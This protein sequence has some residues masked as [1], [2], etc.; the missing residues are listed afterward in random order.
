M[1]PGKEHLVFFENLAK[2]QRKWGPRFCVYLKTSELQDARKHISALAN[3]YRSEI[4]YN[5]KKSYTVRWSSLTTMF[6]PFE[7]ESGMYRGVM[8]AL[9][10]IFIPPSKHIL[11]INLNP[12]MHTTMRKVFKDEL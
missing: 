11:E 10:Y 3:I 4:K 2:K 5:G 1:I 9:N 12:E 7:E 8:L 6:I